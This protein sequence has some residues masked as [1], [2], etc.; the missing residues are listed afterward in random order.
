MKT[1]MKEMKT[2]IKQKWCV[3][4]ECFDTYTKAFK[5]L[6]TINP[7]ITMRELLYEQLD[8]DI[9]ETETDKH[10][11]ISWIISEMKTKIKQKWCVGVEC[12]DTYTQ[13]HLNILKRLILKLQ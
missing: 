13:K 5:Y 10:L 8:S 11:V 9:I 1:E 3:G 2:K 4:V 12:F 7:E 6:K